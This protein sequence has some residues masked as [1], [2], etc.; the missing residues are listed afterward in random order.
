MIFF[1]ANF[2]NGKIGHMFA[3]YNGVSLIGGKYKNIP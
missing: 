1:R 2:V 3:E